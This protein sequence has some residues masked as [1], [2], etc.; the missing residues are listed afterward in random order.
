MSFSD[1]IGDTFDSVS[2]FMGD[3]MSDPL[4]LTNI[5]IETDGPTVIDMT[6]DD[7]PTLG[8][9]GWY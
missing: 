3:F 5:H 7:G 2:D 8:D 4:G 9:D 1:A 6:I